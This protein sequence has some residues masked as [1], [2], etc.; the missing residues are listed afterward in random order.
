MAEY[1]AEILSQTFILKCKEMI[2]ENRQENK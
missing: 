2:N 1:T